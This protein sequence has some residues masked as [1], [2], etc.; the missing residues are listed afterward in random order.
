MR[1]KKISENVY[2]V[3]VL[4]PCVRICDIIVKTEY[5]TTYNAYI[6]K[7]NGKSA[8]VDTVH[9]RFFDEYLENI[10]DV[11]GDTP[12]DY[13][14]MNHN[15]PDHSGSVAKLTEI[16]PEITVIES[17]AGAIYLKNIVNKELKVKTVVDSETFDLG[18]DELKF[19]IAPFLHW[20]DTMF[21]YFAKDRVLFTCDFLGAHFCEPKVFDYNIKYRKEYEAEFAH[22]Y[23]A[24]FGPF[25]PYVLA[26]L[27]KIKD[28]DFDTVCTSHG[29]VLTKKGGGIEHAKEMY[30]EWSQTHK[31]EVEQIPI[32]FCSAYGNTAALAN[33][34]KSGIT[35]VKP[36]ANVEIYDLNCFDMGKLSQIM[37]DSDAFL[38]GSPTIN[39]DAVLPAW[40]L[41]NT[42]DAVSMKGRACAV[43]GSYGWSGEGCG[44][45]ISRLQ[46]LKLKVGET[47]CRCQF[48]PSKSELAEA[49][50]FGKEFAESLKIESQG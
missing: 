16:Y 34:I 10:K 1:V 31:N 41:I 17:K 4:N 28:I 49:V 33:H 2:S 5:G 27:D 43:F 3:G 37:H 30:A 6:I 38:I 19:I 20:P 45:L 24:I 15:E 25:K 44:N 7:N 8:L 11:L 26:G 35:E 50:R 22:Y 9:V 47:P 14:I 42:I 18:E 40:N 46:G 36:N 48:I 29:P 23:A 21:T 12:P 39:R 32:F 13:L